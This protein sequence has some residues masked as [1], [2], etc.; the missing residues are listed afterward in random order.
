MQQ[1]ATISSF[2]VFVV[3]TI[4]EATLNDNEDTPHRE[5]DA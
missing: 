2:V 3:N 1:A 5:R 4:L